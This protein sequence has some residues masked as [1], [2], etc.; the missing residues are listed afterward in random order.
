MRECIATTCL[1]T[2]E[3]EI[4]SLTN[5]CQSYQTNDSTLTSYSHPA[6]GVHP[7]P[8]NFSATSDTTPRGHTGKGLRVSGSKNDTR[9]KGTL[10]SQGILRYVKRSISAITSR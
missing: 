8:L 2:F 1:Q 6:I 9:K 7:K 4:L 10:S 3:L 5:Q